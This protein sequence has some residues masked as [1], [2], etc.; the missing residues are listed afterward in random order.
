MAPSFQM[1][2][3]PNLPTS[4]KETTEE[5]R[6]AFQ[7]LYSTAVSCSD[8]SAIQQ[9]IALPVGAVDEACIPLREGSWK[10]SCTAGA[11]RDMEGAVKLDWR[12]D[13]F[14]SMSDL[15]LVVYDGSGGVT[16]HVHTLLLVYGGRRSGFVVEQLKKQQNGSNKRGGNGSATNDHNN[17][18]EENDQKVEIYIPPLA[19]RSLPIF[20]DYVYGSHLQLTTHNAPLLR[21]LSNRFDVRDLHKEISTKF[22]PQDLELNTAP[23][24]CIAADELKDFE[25]RDKAIR[26][27][28]ERMDRLN[29][30]SLKKITPRLM[31]SLV[32]CEKLNCGNGGSEVLSEKIGTW[33]R[34]REEA[35]NDDENGHDDGND[36]GRIPARSPGGETVFAPVAPLTD[37]DFYWL[38][39]VQHLPRIS[40]REALFFLNYGDQRFPH[41]MT[42][43]IGSGSL[44]SR[45]LAA[46]SERRSGTTSASMT[47]AMDHLV[48]HL[49]CNDR[50]DE[51]RG[52]DPT[53][54]LYESLT[55]ERKVQLLEASLVGAKRFMQE[56]EATTSNRE[57]TERDAKLSDEIMYENLRDSSSKSSLSST[58]KKIV[59]LGTGISPANGIYLSASHAVNA[60]DS[61]ANHASSM[62]VFEK[63]AVW[64]QSR[65]T[66]VLYPT[67]AGQYYTQY[68][69]GVRRNNQQM[70]VL[71]NSPTVLG[72]VGAPGR[73][74][75]ANDTIPEKGW[76]VEE[77]GVHPPPQ[78][79]GRL[80]Q[81][82]RKTLTRSIT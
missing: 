72:M 52:L 23:H 41:V 71:Y 8:L 49:E 50:N 17:K 53:M 40:P 37:E 73:E 25:L 66:F 81:P 21:Y 64:N 47:W 15:Q 16:Y 56:A 62:F 76:E 22:I 27:M 13:P 30:N 54:K 70:T 38:T 68:K 44:L 26:I 29:V 79:V 32:S 34:C 1:P 42:N 33:L 78:F 58:A 28:A 19:A 60:H 31:R 80:E 14:L 74:E 51:N 12:A 69:L 24:Y 61:Y 46:C 63:E 36:R 59:V 65:V 6:K 43:E 67:K 7:S 45:C 48:S 4:A 10:D 3:V 2:S 39:H 11:G 18:S 82:Q 20:L 75:G 5:M 35:S 57:A 77:E 9:R 55:A